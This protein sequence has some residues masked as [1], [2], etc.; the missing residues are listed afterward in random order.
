MRRYARLL[1]VALSS[2][3]VERL[4]M[5]GTARA[6]IACGV[7]DEASIAIDVAENQN[8]TA[9]CLQSLGMT[10][11]SFRHYPMRNRIARGLFSSRV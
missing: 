2:K 7:D 5:S 4:S 8:C 10:E 6:R 11:I 9:L 1:L 3:A